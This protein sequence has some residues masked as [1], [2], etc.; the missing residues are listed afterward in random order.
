MHFSIKTPNFN[1]IF[2]KTPLNFRHI[3]EFSHFQFF[4]IFMAIKNNIKLFHHN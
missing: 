4:V 3:P 2:R 1:A